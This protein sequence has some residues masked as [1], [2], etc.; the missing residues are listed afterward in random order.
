MA[1]LMKKLDEAWVV[2]DRD[3]DPRNKLDK[4]HF[5]QALRS[6]KSK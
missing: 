2:L 4:A 5:N 1:N 6:C 3:A